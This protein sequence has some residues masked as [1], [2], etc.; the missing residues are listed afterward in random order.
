MCVTLLGSC[1]LRAFANS[2]KRSSSTA[3]TSLIGE[4]RIKPRDFFFVCGRITLLVYRL[5]CI[6]YGVRGA[7]EGNL[8]SAIEVEGSDV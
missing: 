3:I 4:C 2:A 6:F 1:S 5:G 8:C 7:Q